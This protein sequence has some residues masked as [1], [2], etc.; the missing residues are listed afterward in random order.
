[1]PSAEGTQS[2]AGIPPTEIP[3]K[4]DIRNSRDTSNSK[5]LAKVRK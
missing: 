4:G 3:A 2:T 1:M 5:V